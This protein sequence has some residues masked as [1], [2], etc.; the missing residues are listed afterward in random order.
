MLI[1][2]TRLMSSEGGS[3]MSGIVLMV[4]A[5]HVENGFNFRFLIANSFKVINL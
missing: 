5:V 1:C 4:A 3:E 2:F